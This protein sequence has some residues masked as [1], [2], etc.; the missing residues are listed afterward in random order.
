MRRDQRYFD[1]G[2]FVFPAPFTYGNSGR[3]VLI[4][5]GTNSIDLSVH[6]SFRLPINEASELQF[7][8]EP[9]NAFNRPHFDLPGSTIGTPSAGVIAATSLPNRELQFGLKFVF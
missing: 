4:G 9:F 5:P 1:I 3:S 8:A 7:R 2:A 6:R